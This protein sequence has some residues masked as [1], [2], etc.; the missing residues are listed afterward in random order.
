MAG[1]MIKEEMRTF[2]KPIDMS[3]EDFIQRMMKINQFIGL[4]PGPEHQYDDAEMRSLIKQACPNLWLLDLRKHATYPTMTLV[5]VKA[6]F[7]LLESTENHQ[8]TRQTQQ[9]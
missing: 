1:K 9:N 4:C 2:R 7:K 5:Q 8:W 3:V 6:Y